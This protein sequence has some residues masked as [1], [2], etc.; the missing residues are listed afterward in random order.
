MLFAE[1]FDSRQPQPTVPYPPLAE[2]SLFF[3]P[4]S[5]ISA[6]IHKETTT[7]KNPH[8]IVVGPQLQRVDIQLGHD[9]M[10]IRVGLRPG[11]LHRLLGLPMYELVDKACD[12]AA[13]FYQEVNAVNDRLQHTDG[14][15]EMIRVVE[16]FLLKRLNSI[17]QE[18]P[19]DRA[20][21]ELMRHKGLLSIEA[22]ASLACVSLR[23]F[24]RQCHARIGLPPKLFARLIRFSNAYRLFESKP[25]VTWT[26]L[27]HHCGYYDQMH[28]I[29]DCREFAG[30][31]PSV[32]AREVKNAP[33][34][35]QYMLSF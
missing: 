11:A 13:F 18:L 32:I 26:H 6:T 17:R 30:V 5:A 24:E 34:H 20:M 7:I 4:R 19:F 27:A 2:Q 22:V 31:T 14:D 12:T 1:Q 23:Q 15:A 28:F 9:H 16:D 35:L 33:V 29:R 8:S 21:Q 10:V 3:Y 25:S